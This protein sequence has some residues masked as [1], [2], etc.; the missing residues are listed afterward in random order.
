VA[1]CKGFSYGLEPLQDSEVF[2]SS[3]F[4]A[5]LG[6]LSIPVII[7]LM[8][9][10]K[11]RVIK[12]GT[13][14]FLQNCQRRAARRTRIKQLILMALRML[15]LALIVLGM[16]KPVIQSKETSASPGDMSTAMILIIDNS[17]SMGYREEGKTRLERAKSVAMQLLDTLKE[18]SG[19]EAAVIVMNDKAQPLHR[20]FQLDIPS[21][22]AAVA[23]IELS[24]HGT[25]VSPALRMAYANMRGTQKSRRE[26]HLLTDLQLFSWEKLI[27]KNFVKSEE[28]PRPRLYISSFGRPKSPNTYIRNI[29]VSGSAAGGLGSKI[30]V[31]VETVGGGSPENVVTLSV[32]S[33]KKEQAAFTVRPGA[34]AQVPVEGSFDE[35]GTY[36]CS[37]AL[38]KDSLEIDDGFEF[39]L[40]IDD[41]VTVLCVDGDPSGIASLSETFFLGAA[42]NPSAMT[43]LRAGSGIEPKMISIAELTAT[44]VEPFKCVILCNVRALDGRDL[45]KLESSL[46]AG[47]SLIMFLGNR[48]QAEEYNEWSFIPATLGNIVGR[49]DK[50][51]FYSFGRVSPNH[52]VFAGMGD[53]RTAKV[54]RCFQARPREGA[55]VIAQ[56]RNDLPVIIE[57]DYGRGRVMMVTTAV[58]LDWSNLPLR[59]IYVPIVHRMV[60]YMS[61]RKAMYHAYSVGDT[62][63]FRALAKHYKER[64]KVITPDG[65]SSYVRPKIEGS[66]AV[67]TFEQTAEPGRYKVLA[68]KDFSNHDGFSVNP[69]VSESDV[70]MIPTRKLEEEF[71]GL[72]VTVLAKPGMVVAQVTETRE[73]WKLW[74]LLFKLALLFFCIEIL[75]ANLFSR[76]VEHE[77]VQMPLFDYLKLRRSGGLSE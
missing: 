11:A 65:K 42:L 75:V 14:R 51:T 40:T 30:L 4:L 58:D 52:P 3:V 57:R 24:S 5:G 17:Y 73:G 38:N 70:T 23:K 29:S 72:D 68:H 39:S 13:I 76:T 48:V 61:G 55:R 16:S 62:V 7:H 69:D 27:E 47:G 59:R 53:L 35:P 8:H 6:A 15:L 2:L 34:P 9:S 25:E 33:E 1:P 12:F 20:S 71:K 31:E 26:I 10:A 43:G 44:D 32:N 77:G 45:L 36:R 46:N 63:E 74:P 18:D 66:Y 64:I 28:E 50:K 19:D 54:F 37:V 56:L 21:V 49:A 22:K 60:A 67:A 41:R